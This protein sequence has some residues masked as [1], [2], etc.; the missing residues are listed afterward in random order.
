MNN[1]SQPVLSTAQLILSLVVAMVVGVGLTI[2]VILPAE[3][4]TDPSGFGAASGLDKLA[5]QNQAVLKIEEKAVISNPE[6]LYIAIDPETTRAK[7]DEFGD[8]LP[9]V[10]GANTISFGDLSFVERIRGR[11]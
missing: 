3:Q 9:V 5:Y 7:V 11:I 4:G 6:A 8:S 1:S 10:D 2:L